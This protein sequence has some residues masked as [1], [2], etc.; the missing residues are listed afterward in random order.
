ML[1]GVASSCQW[2]SFFAVAD[3]TASGSWWPREDREELLVS[4]VAVVAP[5]ANAVAPPRGDPIVA[6]GPSETAAVA[7]HPRIVMILFDAWIASI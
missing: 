2:A 1:L 4:N 6:A 3:T 5:S 7:A